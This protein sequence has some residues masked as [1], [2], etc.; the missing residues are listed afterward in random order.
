MAIPLGIILAL[1]LSTGVVFASGK[2]PALVVTP[3]NGPVGTHLSLNGSNFHAGDTITIGYTTGTC[4][5]N[6]TTISGAT[7]TVA[8]DGSINISF[9]WPATGTGDFTLCAIDGSNAYPSSNKFHVTSANA[10]AITVTSPVNA[11]GQVTVKGTNFLLTNG[12][13]VEVLYGP[14]GGNGC[15]TSA[16]TTPINADGTFTLTFNA[17]QETQDT[18]VVVTAVVPQGSCSG[19]PTLVAT[20]NLLIKAALSA[21]PTPAATAQPTTT[22]DDPTVAPPAAG[23]SHDPPPLPASMGSSLTLVARTNDSGSR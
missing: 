9:T 20:Q 17:P 1:V 7:G 8:G 11:G 2:G 13:T 19:S 12:G 16:G 4:S 15:A 10:P 3:D 5:P 21:T 22:A 18:T 14:Q 6:V 23:A